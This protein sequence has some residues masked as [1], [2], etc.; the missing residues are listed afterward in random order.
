[1]AVRSSTSMEV[2]ASRRRGVD[3]RRSSPAAACGAKKGITVSRRD[4]RRV[5]RLQWPLI[6]GNPTLLR[7]VLARAYQ[8]EMAL[9]PSALSIRATFAG[10]AVISILPFS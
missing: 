8:N 9:S 10:R 7:R 4:G 6:Y 2:S 1:M 5:R 3:G